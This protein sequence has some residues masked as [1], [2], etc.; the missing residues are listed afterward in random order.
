LWRQAAIESP[1]SISSE[2]R[3]TV[4][5][6]H[7]VLALCGEGVREVLPPSSQAQDWVAEEG[8]RRAG[9]EGVVGW[10]FDLI[11]GVCVDSDIGYVR[12]R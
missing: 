10:Q 9:R 4:P 11:G 5:P 3:F 7:P 1:R 6:T 2:A 12:Q 8:A